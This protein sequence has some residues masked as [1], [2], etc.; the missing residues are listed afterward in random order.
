MPHAEYDEFREAF[1]PLL[2]LY[3]P[4]ALRLR[5]ALGSAIHHELDRAGPGPISTKKAHFVRAA[6]DLAG[7]MWSSEVPN[8]I[9]DN[10]KSQGQGDKRVATALL[11]LCCKVK[12]FGKLKEFLR[13]TLAKEGYDDPERPFRLP[14]ED[15]D[16]APSISDRP[17]T[18]QSKAVGYRRPDDVQLRDQLYQ[19]LGREDDVSA[20]QGNALIST[21]DHQ[22]T[23]RDRGRRFLETSII[24]YIGQHHPLGVGTVSILDVDGM[25]KIVKRFGLAVGDQALDVIASILQHALPDGAKFGLCGSDAYYV[26]ICGS[27]AADTAAVM[28]TIRHRIAAYDWES[29]ASDLWVRASIGYAANMLLEGSADF[30]IRAAIGMRR[31]KQAGGDA[32]MAGPE[33]LDRSYLYTPGITYS[34]WS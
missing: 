24:L 15:R 29:V 16:L 20:E 25:T 33:F 27:N 14:V 18:V 11:F 5:K 28:G 23:E 3:S 26:I 9:V 12:S 7:V 17:R 19:Q 30:A 2:D 22:L 31:A 8:K 13:E 1:E 6:V 21:P 32:V 4:R 10:L 34:S